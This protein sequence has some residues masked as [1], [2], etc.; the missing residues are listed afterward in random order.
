MAAEANLSVDSGRDDK[1]CENCQNDESKYRCPAC[2]TRTCSLACTKAHRD[3][4]GLII[5]VSLLL[6]KECNVLMRRLAASF[7]SAGTLCVVIGSTCPR[8]NDIPRCWFHLSRECLFLLR[9]ILINMQLLTGCLGKRSRTGLV[10]VAD[11]TEKQ[12]LADIRFLEEVGREHNA[13]RRREPQRLPDR[14]PPILQELRREVAF[15]LLE[16]LLHH[17]FPEQNSCISTQ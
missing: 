9:A 6:H 16:P 2:G 5:A 3:S 11:F 14:L 8:F 7:S 13:A 10:K 15:C 4:T 12:L 17:V 1:L